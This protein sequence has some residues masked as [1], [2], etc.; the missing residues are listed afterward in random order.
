[1]YAI[2]AQTLNAWDYCHKGNDSWHVI[3]VA[4]GTDKDYHVKRLE[5][6]K[7]IMS[8]GFD[9]RAQNGA[10]G[11]YDLVGTCEDFK[12]DRPITIEGYDQRN[13]THGDERSA[14]VRTWDEVVTWDR[15]ARSSKEAK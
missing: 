15:E 8:R 11:V 3:A 7:E 9:P 4:L 2:F 1:M 5:M 12:L 6:V 14:C 13:A 10:A